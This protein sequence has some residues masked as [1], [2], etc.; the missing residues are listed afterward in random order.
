MYHQHPRSTCRNPDRNTKIS[1]PST[2]NNNPTKLKHQKTRG[3]H[4]KSQSAHSTPSPQR[5]ELTLWQDFF[6][7]QYGTYRELRLY[8]TFFFH[9]KIVLN[10]ITNIIVCRCT[11]CI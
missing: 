3:C 10:T 8:E 2:T 7:I 4:E 11:K 1:V 9:A 5:K 6:T